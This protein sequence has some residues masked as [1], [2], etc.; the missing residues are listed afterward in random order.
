M[1]RNDLIMTIRVHDP[2]E[3]V[4]ADLSASWVTINIARVDAAMP[5]EEFFKKYVKP[6]FAH[7]T[8][9]KFS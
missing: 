6:A 4:D 3:K 7:L 9:L 8:N 2:V 5:I 1:A